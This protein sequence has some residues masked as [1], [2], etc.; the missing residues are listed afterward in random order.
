MAKPGGII[1]RQRGK[2][3]LKGQNTGMGN[4]HTVFALVGGVVKMER[5]IAKSGKR[6]NIVHVIPEN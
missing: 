4:D 2:K 5:W 1:V 3:F 6:K